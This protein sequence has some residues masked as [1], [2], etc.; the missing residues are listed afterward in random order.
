MK[1]INL[2]KFDQV[3]RLIVKFSLEQPCWLDCS[4]TTWTRPCALNYNIY[5]YSWS[6]LRIWVMNTATLNLSVW[7]YCIATKR[8]SQSGN[9]T[10]FDSGCCA[11]ASLLM[12][13]FRLEWHSLHSPLRYLLLVPASASTTDTAADSSEEAVFGLCCYQKQVILKT[14]LLCRPT[15]TQLKTRRII[16]RPIIVTASFAFCL[17][18]L[19]AWHFLGLGYVSPVVLV[20]VRPLASRYSDD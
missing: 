14:R 11:C 6:Q 2:R 20:E 13:W 10:S 3:W 16:N 15:V 19:T 17:N 18:N 1:H 5:A 9:A 12:A 8:L 7:R 4:H